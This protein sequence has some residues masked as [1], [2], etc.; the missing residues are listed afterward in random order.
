MAYPLEEEIKG[1]W[2][3]LTVS[4]RRQMLRKEQV[5]EGPDTL[6]LSSSH[7]YPPSQ[8]IIAI[9]NVPLPPCPAPYPSSPRS[10]LHLLPST[11]HASVLVTTNPLPVNE[12]N[13]LTPPN[14]LTQDALQEQKLQGYQS[15]NV[16]TAPYGLLSHGHERIA[17]GPDPQL[18]LLHVPPCTS[19]SSSPS[20][21]RTFDTLHD[22]LDGYLACIVPGCHPEV[23]A[24]VVDLLIKAMESSKVRACDHR[25]E[26]DEV[27]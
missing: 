6:V 9:D 26:A 7:A 12:A 19:S 16:N 10:Y 5:S 21:C 25:S 17:N 4:H 20:S 18:V 24:A 23:T 22:C 13:T 3:L 14:I 1:G 11:P 8:I 2:R 27:H 15:Q